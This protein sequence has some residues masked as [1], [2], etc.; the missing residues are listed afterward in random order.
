MRVQTRHHSHL[1]ICPSAA[2]L[3]PNRA[4]LCPSVNHLSRICQQCSPDTRINEDPNVAEKELCLVDEAASEG[5]TSLTAVGGRGGGA[6]HL[7]LLLF[8][9][10]GEAFPPHQLL[11]KLLKL[12]LGAEEGAFH[13]QQMVPIQLQEE[14]EEA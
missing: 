13:P 11:L 1:Q 12:L 10:G 9:Q 4:F 3:A 5:S 8:L 2:F 14:E 6:Y 7:Q